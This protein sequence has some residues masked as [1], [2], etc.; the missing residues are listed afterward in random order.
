MPSKEPSILQREDPLLREKAKPVAV[1]DIGSPKIKKIIEDMKEAMDSQKDGIAIAAP[2]IGQSLQIFLVSG[3]LL[4]KADPDHN[5]DGSDL[6]FI[7]P[8]ITKLSKDKELMEEGCLSVRWLY[9]K[10][11]RSTRASI[12]AIN[13]NGD[14]ISRGASG[15]LAQ[16][17]QHECDHLNG[18]LFIDKANEVW[19]MS[20]DEIKELKK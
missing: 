12:T 3:P 20:E 15:L 13:G 16:I 1:A 10:V 9:G 19:E 18:I 14:K 4:K 11:P 2:Q 8:K 5:G 6:V 7:N 17:F